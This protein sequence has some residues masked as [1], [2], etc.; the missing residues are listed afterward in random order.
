MQMLRIF[1][2]AWTASKMFSMLL[3]RVL[4]KE[5]SLQA[6]L[7]GDVIK[8]TE[9]RKN[10]VFSWGS[11]SVYM[12]SSELDLRICWISVFLAVKQEGDYIFLR[13]FFCSSKMKNK[14]MVFLA[15]K[16]KIICFYS[17][18]SELEIGKPLTSF[19]LPSEQEI[20][21]K[22]NRNSIQSQNVKTLYLSGRKMIVCF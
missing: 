17:S 9:T 22:G 19:K 14:Q 4:T 21:T 20:S 7:Y 6:C 5:N 16:S 2:D 11:T 13:V 8:L 18:K 1:S 10:R 3:L 12:S 15:M